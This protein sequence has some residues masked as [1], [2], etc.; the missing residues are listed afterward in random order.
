MHPDQLAD[1]AL[2]ATGDAHALWRWM[3]AHAPVHRHQ[4]GGLPAFW[5]VTRY[6]DVRAVYTDHQSFSSA[7]GVLLRPTA[8]GADPGG[9][10]TLA[11][12]DPPRHRMLRALLAPRFSTRAAREL[13]EALRG[14]VHRVL[15]QAVSAGGCD[16]AQDVAARLST[17]TVCRLTGVPDGDHELFLRWTGEAFAA[18][19]P[20]LAHPELIAYLVELMYQR[21]EASRPDL[22]GALVDAAELTEEEI[23]LNMENLVGAS[24]NAGLSMAG[25]VLT[26]LDH[27]DQWRRL[28]QDRALV[29]SAM[30]E[31][32]RWTSS[33][34]HSMRTATRTVMVRGRRIEAGDRVVVWLPSANRDERIFADPDRFDV[35]RAPNR[36]LALGFGEHV[37]IGGTV[38]RTQLRT[39][40]THLLDLDARI[41][42]AG[43]VVRLRS[44]AVSGPEHLPV[45]ITAARAGATPT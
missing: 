8:L 28:R 16:F 12:T 20:L 19:R 37:C 42:H 5:S 9:G 33:A 24:E 29:P 36:H 27:P 30:E 25:G 43:P 17:L 45:R 21:M 4:A 39:L 15:G 41:E 3:R 23:L 13:Q 6:H 34:T 22:M 10:M 32:L 35:G 11:L 18:A 1:P 14:D 26:L 38:A 31:L 40:L 44:V 2:H 7:H